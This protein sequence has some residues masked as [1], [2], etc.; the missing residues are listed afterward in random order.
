MTRHSHGRRAV[1]A[2]TGV[3]LAVLPWLSRVAPNLLVISGGPASVIATLYAALLLALAIDPEL[4]PVAHKIGA[5]LAVVV[6]MGRGGGFIERMLL[7]DRTDLIPAV[8]ERAALCVLLVS[9]HMLRAAETPT[10][11]RAIER[12][13]HT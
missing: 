5:A 8:G 2:V 1:P 4:P 7:E 10:E 13:L 9:W 6:W 12:A 11:P 3:T